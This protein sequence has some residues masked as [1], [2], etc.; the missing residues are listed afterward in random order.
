MKIYE[1]AWKNIVMPTQIQSKK[2]LLGP[3]E[4][5]VNGSKV[6][7]VDLEVLNRNNKKISGFLFYCPEVEAEDTVLYMHGNGGSKI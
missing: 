3:S 7:R 5:I 4:R 2:H 6:L 1:N